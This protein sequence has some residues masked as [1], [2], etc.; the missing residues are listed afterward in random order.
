VHPRVGGQHCRKELWSCALCLCVRRLTCVWLRMACAIRMHVC[1]ERTC[2]GRTADKIVGEQPRT[3]FVGCLCKSAQQGFVCVVR[4]CMSFAAATGG[5]P[6]VLL[7][8]QGPTESDSLFA[9]HQVQ[10]DSTTSH[11]RW[12]TADR[13]HMGWCCVTVTRGHCAAVGVLAI[14]RSCP[15]GP[16]ARLSSAAQRAPA[17]FGLHRCWCAC[18][19][20]VCPC[21]R[22]CLLIAQRFLLCPL[23]QIP[24]CFV[25]SQL[26]LYSVPQF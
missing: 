20:V 3:R 4:S 25:A 10:L 23:Q 22:A 19:L 15:S 24:R 11:E 5:A 18:L 12:K 1:S 6:C 21:L 17:W 2:A 9:R 26:D 16:C 14:A 13:F 7:I 8:R